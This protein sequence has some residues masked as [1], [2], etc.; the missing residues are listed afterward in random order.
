MYRFLSTY[1][2]PREPGEKG[3]YSNL[4]VALLG[5]L[6]G[7]RAGVEYEALLKQRVLD[8]LGMKSTSIT[9]TPDQTARLAPGHSPYL[10]PEYVWEMRAMPAS[11][12]LRSTANDMLRFLAAN[13]GYTDTS[14]KE[15]IGY[16][17]EPRIPPN[18]IR[19]Q[20]PGW[21]LRKIGEERFYEKDGGKSGYRA[22][23]IIRPSNRTGIVV[24]ENART[25]DRPINLA[26]HILAGTPLE[27]AP[28]A[29]APRK[30]VKVNQKVLASYAGRYEKAPGSVLVIVPKGDRLLVAENGDQGA[31]FYPTS[32]RDFYLGWGNDEMSFD[33]DDAGHVQSVRY[34]PD[35]RE[36]GNVRTAQR[37]AN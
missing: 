34:Y 14:L 17:L 12:S 27:P 11:G 1:Q 3:E 5:R 33:V 16:Q 7:R 13:L 22:E 29:P 23:V 36:A 32:A 28:A 37:V 26:F 4:A 10:Q 15:A 21:T 25:D 35:G 8:P 30:I 24:L 2:L 31:F 19:E 20:V 9:L 18:A 6:L